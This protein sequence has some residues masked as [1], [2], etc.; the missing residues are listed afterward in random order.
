MSIP[1]VVLW[2][3]DGTLVVPPASGVFPKAMALLGHPCV[4]P[5]VRHGLTDFGRAAVLLEDAGASRTLVPELLALADSLTLSESECVPTVPIPGASEA[6]ARL[7]SVGLIQGILT[8][9]TPER[10]RTKLESAGLGTSWSDPTMIFT[11]EREPD[12][13]SLGQRARR[14]AGEVLLI[15]IGDSAEDVRAAHAAQARFYRVTESSSPNRVA[16]RIV[17]DLGLAV[18]SPGTEAP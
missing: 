15:L 18:P 7:A 1:G 16:Y 8:G 12:R 17:A 2:D 5:V 11:G 4:H 10:M 6:L 13:A 14:A 3:L 9:N